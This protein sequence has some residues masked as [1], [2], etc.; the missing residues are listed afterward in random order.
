MVVQQ[1]LY[2]PDDLWKL[3]HQPGEAKRLELVKGEIREMTPTGALHGVVTMEVGRLI[4]NYVRSHDLGY[5]TGAETGFI[6][7][8]DPYTVRAPDVGMIVNARITFPIPEKY[9]P[10]APD[11]AVEVVSPGDTAQDIREKVIQFLQAGT[12]LVWV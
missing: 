11:L 6:L 8:D 12:R 3:S 5:V 9:F 4:A 1:K 7:R 10:L 2:T